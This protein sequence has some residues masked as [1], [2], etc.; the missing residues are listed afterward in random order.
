MSVCESGT[1]VPWMLSFTVTLLVSN[2]NLRFTYQ[3]ALTHKY[4]TL[5]SLKMK[6]KQEKKKL[7]PQHWAEKMAHIPEIE[8][9]KFDISAVA[10]LLPESPAPKATNLHQWWELQKLN[11]MLPTSQHFIQ[12]WESPR[13]PSQWRLGTSLLPLVRKGTIFFTSRHQLSFFSCSNEACMAR[14][15][16]AACTTSLKA[17]GKWFMAIISSV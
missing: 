7:R 12:H 6:Q 13:S 2:D 8:K 14:S 9:Q 10:K 16:M 17:C 1:R 4:I 3:V 5:L 11:Y 15:R